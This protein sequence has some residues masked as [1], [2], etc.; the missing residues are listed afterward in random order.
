MI[1]TLDLPGGQQTLRSTEK[2]QGIMNACLYEA[3]VDSVSW[4]GDTIS[5]TFQGLFDLIKHGVHSPEIRL[6]GVSVVLAG[7]RGNMQ[8]RP[9][10]LISTAIKPTAEGVRSN[11]GGWLNPIGTLFA[12]S[13]DQY[14]EVYV[15]EKSDVIP[16]D[17]VVINSRYDTAYKNYEIIVGFENVEV[18]DSRTGERIEVEAV[19][20]STQV[21][22]DDVSGGAASTPAEVA[23]NSKVPAV[24]SPIVGLPLHLAEPIH[25]Y[26]AGSANLDWDQ[27][28]LAHIGKNAP[29]SLLN[30]MRRHFARL[31]SNKAKR[32][33]ETVTIDRFWEELNKAFVVCCATS[34][35][36]KQFY[37]IDLC[38]TRHG[39]AIQ[40]MVMSGYRP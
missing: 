26:F 38:H 37:T 40:N 4:D 9:S 25:N 30:E 18:Y 17:W 20:G 3:G 2:L 33:V 6:K 32:P 36:E 21:P 24:E 11:I 23:T 19:R 29:Q 7:L 1:K 13:L 5:I 16:R 28:A 39:W 12:R 14:V 8:D 10:A 34:K 27:R 35:K 15:V 31:Y 22:A